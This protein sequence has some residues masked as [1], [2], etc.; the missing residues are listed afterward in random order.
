MA[1]SSGSGHAHEPPEAPEHEPNEEVGTIE[2]PSAPER[3]ADE[4][5]GT[6]EPPS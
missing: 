1:T 6:I 2:P 3:E 4:E 5:V